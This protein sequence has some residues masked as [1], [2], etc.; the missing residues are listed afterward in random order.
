MLKQW[1]AVMCLLSTFVISSCGK[2]PEKA[3]GDSVGEELPT[4]ET[5]STDDALIGKNICQALKSKRI[6]FERTQLG[7]VFKFDFTERRCGQLSRDTFPQR[8]IT[9]LTAANGE[10]YYTG[11]TPA[12][13]IN[14]VV[15]DEKGALQDFCS[16]LLKDETISN[17]INLSNNEKLMIRFFNK[18]AV[19]TSSE[20]HGLATFFAV[21][22]TEGKF[23]IRQIDTMDILVSE[24]PNIKHRGLLLH[25][26]RQTDCGN[27]K[28]ESITQQFKL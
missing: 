17:T 19:Y 8:V 6:T 4:V 16:D 20:V 18:G 21:K 25:R 27:N 12:K 1:I 13:F 22:N 26:T 15:T 5:I 14:S 9:N 28:T 3:E 24:L 23:N 7:R 2:L 10:L 11:T